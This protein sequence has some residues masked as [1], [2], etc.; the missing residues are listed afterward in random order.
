MTYSPIMNHTLVIAPRPCRQCGELI[1]R[2]TK[3]QKVHARCR[4]EWNAA[5][6]RR[7]RGKGA[8]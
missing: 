4:A 3:S 2:P 8:K 5:M 6:T 7:K 1:Q